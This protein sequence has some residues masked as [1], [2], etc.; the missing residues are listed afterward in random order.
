MCVYDQILLPGE[1]HNEKENL[2]SPKLPDWITGSS[3]ISQ[4]IPFQRNGE[5]V[6]MVTTE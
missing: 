2:T 6:K 3:D 1:R 5:K 4:T